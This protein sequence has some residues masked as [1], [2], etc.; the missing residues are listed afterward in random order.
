MPRRAVNRH[1]R[2]PNGMAKTSF[3]KYV[4]IWQALVS[5]RD[6]LVFLSVVSDHGFCGCLLVLLCILPPFL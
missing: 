3:T 5:V 6:V 4:Y 2:G 1:R